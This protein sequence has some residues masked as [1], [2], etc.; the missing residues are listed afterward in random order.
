MPDPVCPF[1]VS[2][3]PFLIALAIVFV[4]RARTSAAFPFPARWFSVAPIPSFV[5]R[6]ALGENVTQ[7]VL[8]AAAFLVPLFDAGLDV[9]AG[10]H[11]VHQL[12]DGKLREPGDLVAEALAEARLRLFDEELAEGLPRHRLCLGVEN[13]RHLQLQ[14]AR[15]RSAAARS[16]AVTAS[17]IVAISWRT[18]V[19]ATTLVAATLVP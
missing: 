9:E 4:A 16:A 19:V 5:L 15:V 14:K 18:A 17:L 11:V 3:F 12:V 1:P 7:P 13:L 6:R 8:R 2:G 10:P